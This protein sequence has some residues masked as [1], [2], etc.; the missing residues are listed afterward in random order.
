MYLRLFYI[1]A[2]SS[3]VRITYLYTHNSVRIYNGGLVFGSSRFPLLP[4]LPQKMMLASK[5]VKIEL[6]NNHLALSVYIRD[7]Q[8]SKTE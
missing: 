7:T 4:K 1:N 8:S 3:T 6:K 2:L 5:V